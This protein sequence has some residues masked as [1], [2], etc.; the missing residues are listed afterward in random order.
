MSETAVVQ[1][2]LLIFG[3]TMLGGVAVTILLDRLREGQRKKRWNDAEADRVMREAEVEAESVR[4]AKELSDETTRKAEEATK[5]EFAARMAELGLSRLDELVVF[6]QKAAAQFALQDQ[7]LAA[8]TA[9][10]RTAT[11]EALATRAEA[12]Q[13]KAQVDQLS[14]TLAAANAT[15]SEL[16]ATIERLEKSFAVN[17]QLTNEQQTEVQ[18]QK[19]IIADLEARLKEVEGERDGLRADNVT[20]LTTIAAL[21]TRVDNLSVE[22]DETKRQLEAVA[23]LQS[24]AQPGTEPIEKPKES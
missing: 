19:V 11:A 1:L 8:A 5:N 17:D 6:Q 12:A 22:L 15:I 2:I 18:S 23:R 20:H 16:K 10:A 13:L 4:K 9:E 7:L 14:V 3:P 21:Q 24:P